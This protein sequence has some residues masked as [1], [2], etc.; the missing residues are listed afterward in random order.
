MITIGL[1]AA[2]D[3]TGIEVC[4]RSAFEPYRHLYTPGAYADTVLSTQG[5]QR[6]LETMIVLVARAESALVVGTVG[7]SVAGNEGHLRGMAVLPDW[8]G[9]GIAQHLLQR[10]ESEL[11]AAGCEQISLDTTL[12]LSRAIAFYT[13]NGYRASG[14]VTDFFGMPLYEY[15]KAVCV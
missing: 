11:A 2:E 12:P 8:Q 13:R 7:A 9:Q 4:L 1:A 10:I 3:A 5:V 14:V 6:R 15:R